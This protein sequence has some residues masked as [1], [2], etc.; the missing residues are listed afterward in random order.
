MF[1]TFFPETLFRPSRISTV[2]SNVAPIWPL[3]NAQGNPITN[4]NNYSTVG[5]GGTNEHQVV[6]KL[7]HNL[8]ARWKLFGTFSRI[9]A[10]QFNIDPL[11]YKVNLT[12]QVTYARTHATA[13][14]TAVFSP[15]LIGEFRTGFARYDSPSVPYALG[16]DITTL[17]FPKALADATQIKSFPAFNVSGLVAVGSS[18]SAG[19]T[20]VDLNSWGQ[21]A[22]M[23]WVKSAHT[24][25][26]GADYR[27]QQL[28]QFQQNSF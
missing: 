13:A 6:S 2:A 12:R 3:P 20:L 16:F 10:R 1:A 24:M 5:G 22:S 18:A 17:G 9:W 4:V 11:G 21:R 23:T 7:D 15:G 26:F 27:I 25:K 19:M 14:A 8:N 28:N